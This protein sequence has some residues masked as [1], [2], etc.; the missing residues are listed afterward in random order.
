MLGLERLG[1][2][3][4]LVF[5]I[6]LEL[7]HFF[8]RLSLCRL[9]EVLLRSRELCLIGVFDFVESMRHEGIYM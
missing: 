8:R 9:D 3:C 7:A 6:S 4:N 2:L 1:E 5:V